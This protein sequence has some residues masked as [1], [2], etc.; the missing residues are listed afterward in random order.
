MTLHE[1]EQAKRAQ[2]RDLAIIAAAVVGLFFAVRA[3]MPEPIPLQDG[4]GFEV[5]MQR[6][7]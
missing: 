5:C 7:C 1:Y 3:T 6:G 2:R 4:P